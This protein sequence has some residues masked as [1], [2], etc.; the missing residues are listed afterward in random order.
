MEDEWELLAEMTTVSEELRFVE[1]RIGTSAERPED[2]DR[3]CELGHRLR[4][5]Q[6]MDLLHTSGFPIPRLARLR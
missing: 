2:F 5:L 3:C 6:Q 4:N 1:T